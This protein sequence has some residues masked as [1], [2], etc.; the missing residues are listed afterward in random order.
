[1]TTRKRRVVTKKPE[2]TVYVVKD[3]EVVMNVIP[4]EVLEVE[5]EEEASD[6]G[7][8]RIKFQTPH[9]E[10]VYEFCGKCVDCG[11]KRPPVDRDVF[12]H[13]SGPRA[14]EQLGIQ[15]AAFRR[16]GRSGSPLCKECYEVWRGQQPRQEARFKVL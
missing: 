7:K 2:E 8:P 12:T 15:L 11:Y 13:K 3:N 16:D 9:G 5:S 1:M 14:D 6:D 10:A 4:E